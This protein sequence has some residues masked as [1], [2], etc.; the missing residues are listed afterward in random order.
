MPSLS[1][2]LHL[3]PIF[4]LLHLLLHILLLSLH[5]DRDPEHQ[6]GGD[7]AQPPVAAAAAPRLQALLRVPGQVVGVP[8]RGQRL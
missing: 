3:L 8:L 4:L 2:F 5:S 6:L 1:S 7:R